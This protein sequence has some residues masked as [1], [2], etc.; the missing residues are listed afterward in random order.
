MTN[1]HITNKT[2]QWHKE[3]DTKILSELPDSVFTNNIHK[4]KLLYWLSYT[5]VIEKWSGNMDEIFTYVFDEPFCVP[6]WHQYMELISA[7]LT[8]PGTHSWLTFLAR[9]QTSWYQW[10]LV[11]TPFPTLKNKKELEELIEQERQLFLFHVP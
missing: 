2:M 6:F 3:W 5:L 1:E 11:H 7:L 9:K 4:Q 8:Y 10:Y